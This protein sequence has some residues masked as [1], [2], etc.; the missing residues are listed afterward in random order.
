M[1]AAYKYP[2]DELSLYMISE[3]GTTALM[4][5]SSVKSLLTV[6]APLLTLIFITELRRS[7]E[8]D[9]E[10]VGSVLS[11]PLFYKLSL[12]LSPLI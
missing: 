7:E 6:R 12:W 11:E 1:P 10:E 9:E 2:K 4:P 8:E 5:A 3:R